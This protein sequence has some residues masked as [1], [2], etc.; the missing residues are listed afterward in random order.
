MHRGYLLGRRIALGVGGG[1][2]AYKVCDLIRALRKE[3]AQ[4]RVA[5]TQ[6]AG[7]FVTALTLQSLSGE[8]VLSNSFDPHQDK[9]FGHLQLARWADVFVIAPATAD[10]LARIRVGMGND[11]VT[12]PLLAFRGPVLLAPAMNTAMWEDARTQGNVQALKADARFHWV[13][14]ES[15][16]LADGD[17]GPGRLAELPALLEAISKLA[18]AG[19][20]AAKRVLVTAGPTREALDPVRF[21]SNPSTGKMGVAMAQVARARGAL[22]TVVLGPTQ[23]LELDGL[24]VINVNTADEMRD[25]VMGALDGIDYFVAAAAVS[26]WKPQTSAKQKQKKGEGPEVLTLERTPDVLMGVSDHFQSQAK[27]P[28]LVGFAAETQE[29]EA[30]AKEKLAKKRLDVVVANDVSAKDAGF[31]AETNR[32]VVL[33]AKGER[34]EA[35]GSKREVAATIWDVIAP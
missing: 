13:G 8:P 2:A 20:L 23:G 19:R 9:S 10:L 16:L 14:P 21:I 22:V 32:V 5:M 29:L 27:K 33:T 11:A 24:E 12:T 3:G 25:A 31:E 35:S 26:D 34:V 18:V 1:I 28:V 30:Y 6:A 4:V 7:E 17:V 15:G